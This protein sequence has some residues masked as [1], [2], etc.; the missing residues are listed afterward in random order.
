MCNYRMSHGAFDTLEIL[1]DY[2]KENENADHK[3]NVR[4]IH[5]P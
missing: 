5:I 3:D 2:L 1:E 4:K